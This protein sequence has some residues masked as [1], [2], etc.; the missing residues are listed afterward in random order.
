MWYGIYGLTAHIVCSPAGF[1]ALPAVLPCV[2]TEMLVQE[3]R[4][5]SSTELHYFRFAAVY[6]IFSVCKGQR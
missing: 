6:I 1:E 4:C 2:R 5:S 3:A